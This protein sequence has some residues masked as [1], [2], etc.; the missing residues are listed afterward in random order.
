MKFGI[1]DI[2]E[3]C[4][5][6]QLFFSPLS[7]TLVQMLARCLVNHNNLEDPLNQSPG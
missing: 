3:S 6:I 7:E 5:S 1:N 4:N 2:E